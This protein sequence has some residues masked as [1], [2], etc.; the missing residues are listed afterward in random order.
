MSLIAYNTFKNNPFVEHHQNC[1]ITYDLENNIL[2]LSRAGIAV[3]FSQKYLVD[4]TIQKK[5]A[6]KQKLNY[7]EH[8]RRLNKGISGS[9]IKPI[10]EVSISYN[11]LEFTSRRKWKFESID[12]IHEGELIRGLNS[13]GYEIEIAEQISI[14]IDA[15]KPIESQ[16]LKLLP[17]YSF[18]KIQAWTQQELNH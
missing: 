6:H 9:T 12:L 17:Q 1:F 4:K 7:I 18:F 2:K 3:Y 14:R 8:Q 13:L 15:T 5:I 16:L 11:D 10:T